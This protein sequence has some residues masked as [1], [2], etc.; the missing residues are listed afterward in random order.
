[1]ALLNTPEGATCT[2][3]HRSS[4]GQGSTARGMSSTVRPL[5]AFFV[6]AT[7]FAWRCAGSCLAVRACCAFSLFREF[8]SV[9]WHWR[10]CG[11][12]WIHLAGRGA[13]VC[14]AMRT[15]ARVP[16]HANGR[17]T[18]LARGNRVQILP[19]YRERHLLPQTAW[20]PERHLI[21]IQRE[22]VCTMGPHTSEGTAI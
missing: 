2:A 14:L 3:I 10:A 21:T 19:R 11:A 5:A 9:A 6:V 16:G 1:M 4:V 12:V 13:C 17:R 15:G 20:P 22:Y 18:C 8:G 7:I